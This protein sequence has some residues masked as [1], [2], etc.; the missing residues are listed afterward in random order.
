MRK[1]SD[2]C[3][4]A[5]LCKT[6]RAAHTSRCKLRLPAVWHRVLAAIHW[7]V[8]APRVRGTTAPIVPGGTGWRDLASGSRENWLNPRQGFTCEAVRIW[9]DRSWPSQRVSLS[10]LYCSLMRVELLFAVPLVQ[11]QRFKLSSSQHP[12][13]C[14]WSC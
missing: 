3:W 11:V 6:K 7:R 13:G 12:S 4:V 9:E 10:F 8:R 14:F 1:E 5:W 2:T